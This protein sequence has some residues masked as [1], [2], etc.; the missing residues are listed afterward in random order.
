MGKAMENGLPWA[1]AYDPAV[2]LNLEYPEVTL[3]S[4]L[5]QTAETKGE[6]TALIYFGKTLTY[7]E[8]AD[9]VSRMAKGLK[10]LRL[11]RGD[12]IAIILPN[13]PQYVISY[14]A[15]LLAGLTVIPVNPLS[16]ASELLHIF[17]DSG[18]QVVV[19]LDL[20]AGRLEGVRDKLQQNGEYRIAQHVYYTSLK[21]FMPFPLKL[22]YPLKQ[23][24]PPEAK[25]C[26][27]DAKTYLSLLNDPGPSLEMPP[28]DVHKDLAV[29][30][31]TG[32]TT[33]KPKGVMLSHYAL[34]VNAVQ[35]SAWVDMKGEDR[36]LTVL[37]LFHGFGMS[38]CMNS[39]IVSGGSSVLLPRFDAG[40]VLKSMAKYKP[41]LFAGVPTLYIALINHSKF[42]KSALSSLKACYVGAAAL[43]PEVKKQFEELTGARLM[44]G[45]G[46]TEAVTAICA[47]PYNGANKTGSIG[48]P[49]SDVVMAIRDVETGEKEL[50]ANEVGEIVLQSPSVM[51]GYYQRPGE[52][53]LVLR[54]GWLYTGDIGYMD[55]D[56]YFYIVDRKKDMIIT[57]GFNVYPREVED[58]LYSHPAIKEASVIGA[59]DPYK[60]ERV[61]AYV[62][63]KD[64]AAVQESEVI[65]FCREH[66]IPY[67][68]PR[69]VEFCRELPKTAI[70]K[71]LKRALRE[72][73]Q[74]Q[75]A[76][77]EPKQQSNT[78]R[79]ESNA[80]GEKPAPP[81]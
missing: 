55:E 70:G 51:L 27:A 69:Q 21:D 11:A 17:R 6:R 42:K 72:M 73:D 64:G 24:M 63:L 32:G 34:V 12:K 66:L 77:H 18:V 7:A 79:G 15:G 80:T 33:G 68:V 19:C 76:D 39:T 65:A 16:T 4:L 25:A 41:T 62:T 5:Q 29:L 37:P 36:R 52:T 57:G 40:N 56:G 78:A 74:Q 20:L 49:F 14:Y 47:N 75:P 23:K 54:N 59:P 35:V 26:L 67:K 81:V 2:P 9:Y 30:I 50:S 3:C 71:V 44:E 10:Q 8:L 61:K 60:G 58:V 1:K 45:Y 38:V 28:L 22:L 46:L 43:A 13:C 48:M 53:A 31:Y